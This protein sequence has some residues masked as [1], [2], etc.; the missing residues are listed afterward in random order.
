MMALPKAQVMAWSAEDM[1]C[2]G[3]GVSAADREER[4]YDEVDLAM[5]DAYG[6]EWAEEEDAFDDEP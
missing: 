4:H 6:D 5:T 2:V 3:A 1:A